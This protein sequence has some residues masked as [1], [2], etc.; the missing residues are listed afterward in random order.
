MTKRW[1]MCMGLSHDWGDDPAGW[2]VLD[3][4]HPLSQPPTRTAPP[5]PTTAPLR[6]N[7][8]QLP[9]ESFEHLL[10]HLVREAEGAVEALVYGRRGQAQDGIDVVGFFD[11]ARQRARVYQAKRYQRFTVADLTAAV[12]TYAQGRRPFDAAHLVIVTSADTADVKIAD[13]MATLSTRYPGLRVDLW[14]RQQLSD[15]LYEHPRVVTRFFG[16]ETAAIFCRPSASPQVSG[17]SSVPMDDHRPQTD[18]LGRVISTLTERDA[19]GLEVHQALQSGGP[20][21]GSATLPS[22]LARSAVDDALRAAVRQSEQHSTLVVLV[23]D[24]SVGK[25]RACWEA[26]RAELPHWRLWHPRGTNVT[27]A[28]LEGVRGNALRPRTVIWL[29]EL[30][31]YLLAR[32][33]AADVAVELLDLVIDKSRGPFLILGTL[34]HTY[35]QA[36][37]RD[38]DSENADDPHRDARTFLDMALDIAVPNKFT[39]QELTAASAIIGDD[40]RLAVAADQAIDGRI[41]QYLAGVPLLLRRYRQAGTAARAVLHAG[42]QARR[43]GHQLLLTEDFLHC[44][45]E[46]YLTAADRLDVGE[47]WFRTALDELTARQ[48]GLPGPLA[49]HLPSPGEPQPAATQYR[50]ADAVEDYDLQTRPAGKAPSSLWA[51]AARHSPNVETMCALADSA[52]RQKASTAEELFVTAAREAGQHQGLR[53]L[54]DHHQETGDLEEAERLAQVAVKLGSTIELRSVALALFNARQH[55]QAEALGLQLARDDD[56]SLLL[57]LGYGAAKEG[58]GEEAARMYEAAA[59]HGD[60]YALRGLLKCLERNGQ[61]DTAERLAVSYARSG[62]LMPL[63]ELG[64]AREKAGNYGSAVRLYTSLGADICRTWL[65]DRAKYRLDTGDITG[66]ELLYAIS[67]EAGSTQAQQQLKQLQHR[68]MPWAQSH[69]VL[70]TLTVPLNGFSGT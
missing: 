21:R 30:Q 25:T 65:P 8:D 7:L 40:P 50:I 26:V 52:R 9:W 59:E 36:L 64:T 6:L 27:T 34:W 20:A 28:V 5:Q 4:A 15:M 29:N 45:A 41:T 22:Y 1:G 31:R 68:T 60:D 39:S 69:S 35:W 3:D 51:A 66:A 42:L 63:F 14:G 23:G 33:D 43:L 49:R 11:Q 2:E 55:R 32:Q 38:P 18:A 61:P 70:H 17:S 56:T 53:W 12:D 54:I 13:E 67:A 57:T 58:R 44:A 10:A 46:G 62:S 19:L 37:A 24:S 48:R 47:N 16:H